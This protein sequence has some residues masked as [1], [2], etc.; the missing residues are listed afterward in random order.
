M[1]KSTNPDP[2]G[3]DNVGIR[4]VRVDKIGLG[5]LSGNKIRGS[6]V[7]GEYHFLL[8]DSKILHFEF[9]LTW[10]NKNGNASLVAFHSVTRKEFSSTYDIIA[11]NHFQKRCN[12]LCEQSPL[13]D[14]TPSP[15]GRWDSHMKSNGGAGRKFWKESLRGTKILLG[16]RGLKCFS[17]LRGISS[18]TANYLLS[19]FFG[20]IP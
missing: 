2:H 3:Q 16:G 13:L 9:V 15:V 17:P 20:S 11:C 6:L 18:K 7:P 12:N 5:V 4:G 19:Y 14:R 8:I 10:S 1:L